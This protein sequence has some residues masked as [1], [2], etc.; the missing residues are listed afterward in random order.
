MEIQNCRAHSVRCGCAVWMSTAAR[1]AYLPDLGLN[2]AYGIDA[3][4]FA[5]QEA[6]RRAEPR[7]LGHGNAGYSALGLA[8]D[9]AQGASGED[10]FAT[11]AR[12]RSV[13]RS[14]DDRTARRVI[15]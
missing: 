12:P 7:L 13:Q 5:T 9:G 6:E 1:A 4:H 2:F 15:R 11:S 8:L 14:A 3:A 10:I